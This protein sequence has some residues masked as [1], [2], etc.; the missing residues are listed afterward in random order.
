MSTKEFKL[1]E[2]TNKINFNVTSADI[3]VCAEDI[4]TPYVEYQGD[5]EVENRNNN[6]FI[7]EKI[8]NNVIQVPDGGIINIG[9]TFINHGVICG[10]NVTINGVNY[11]NAGNNI[12][13]SYEESKVTLYYPAKLDDMN[14]NV[15]GV[16]G[17]VKVDDLMLLRLFVQ[18]VSGDIKILFKGRR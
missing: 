5:F 3:K 6:A 8:E 13:N 1:E 11:G 7:T 15:K 16:S 10:G 4:K 18:T 2:G 9:G 17:N 12:C 14:L